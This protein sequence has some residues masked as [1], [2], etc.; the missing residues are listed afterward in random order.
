[1]HCLSEGSECNPVRSCVL[2]SIRRRTNHKPCVHA[3]VNRTWLWAHVTVFFLTDA[4]HVYTALD[5][6]AFLRASKSS[7][8]TS[9]RG[10]RELCSFLGSLLPVFEFTDARLRGG[11]E[12]EVRIEASSMW[13]GAQAW[14]RARAQGD[15]RRLPN[16]VRR[17]TPSTAEPSTACL[18]RTSVPANKP[19]LGCREEEG[20]ADG[21]GTTNAFGEASV[22]KPGD[23]GG[24]TN[25]FAMDENKPETADG[26]G[27]TNTFSKMSV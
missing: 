5:D 8:A 21:G 9:S 22:A 24:S 27:P 4:L 1:M 2:A 26:G 14:R 11:R 7:S 25:T 3:S 18:S 10:E 6:A 23:G 17:K 13:V 20:A 15:R 16:P 12:G 19:E